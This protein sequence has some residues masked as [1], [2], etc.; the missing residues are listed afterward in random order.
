MLCYFG[1]LIMTIGRS[2]AKEDASEFLQQKIALEKEKKALN[3]SAAE[4]DALLKAKV[5]AIG[6]VFLDLD[7]QF[8]C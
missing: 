4:K 7:R 1:E 5:G 6:Y 8:W 3:D 2:Q